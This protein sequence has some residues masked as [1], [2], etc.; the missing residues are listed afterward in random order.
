MR[1][2]ETFFRFGEEHFPDSPRILRGRTPRDASGKCRNFPRAGSSAIVGRGR[3][4][5]LTRGADDDDRGR[6]KKID[7]SRGG[8]A[9]GTNGRDIGSHVTIA[10]RVIRA[11][12]PVVTTGYFQRIR[13]K[14]QLGESGEHVRDCIPRRRN[15][16]Q[17]RGCCTYES[18]TNLRRARAR[19]RERRELKMSSQKRVSLPSGGGKSVIGAR[20]TS[21]S[22]PGR[23]G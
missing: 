21:S 13:E 12:S 17:C 5:A 19:E 6:K 11:A 9:A 22:F 20:E 10:S 1:I 16:S 7:F 2:R 8:I 4:Y 23:N 14:Q 15:C 18:R 3:R